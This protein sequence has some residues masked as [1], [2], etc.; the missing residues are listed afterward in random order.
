MRIFFYYFEVFGINEEMCVK[1][2]TVE[3]YFVL[4]WSELC[5]MFSTLVNKDG[6]DN[7]RLSKN[8]VSGNQISVVK[9]VGKSVIIRAILI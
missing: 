5:F 4:G 8:L 7:Y 6:P 9:S 3:K 1:N 2:N